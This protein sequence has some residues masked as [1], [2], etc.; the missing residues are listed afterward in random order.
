M[1]DTEQI[2]FCPGIKLNV[3]YKWDESLNMW[4]VR[5]IDEYGHNYLAQEPSLVSDDSLPAA[6]C[7]KI[8]EAY[9]IESWRR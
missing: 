2:E 6:V 7:E 9:K 3:G 8:L 5:L 4:S 1:L